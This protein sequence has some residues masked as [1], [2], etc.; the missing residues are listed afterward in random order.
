M[1]AK[2]EAEVIYLMVEHKAT[3]RTEPESVWFAGLVEEVAELGQSLVGK[4]EHPP[5]I[6][7]RQIAAI[8]LNWLDMREK[9][10][11]NAPK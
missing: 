6:E 2:S 11:S 7:L 10:Q 3:W 9:E 8:C 5:E 1:S 4:H